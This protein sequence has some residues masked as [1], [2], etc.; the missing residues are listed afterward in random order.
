MCPRPDYWPKDAKTHIERAGLG[1]MGWNLNVPSIERHGA[2]SFPTFVDLAPKQA[3]GAPQNPVTDPDDFVM[4]GQPLVP[5]CI[6]NAQGK[7]GTGLGTDPATFP[8]ELSGWTYYHPETD[9]FVRAFRAPDYSSWVVQTKSGLWMTFGVPLDD[10]ADLSG[11]E[12]HY[13]TTFGTVVAAA[14]NT[15]VYRWDLV[16]QSDAINSSVRNE[17]VYKWASLWQGDGEQ[18][19]SQGYGLRYLTD[20]YDTRNI[21]LGAIDLS[22]FAHHTHLFWRG[23]D[24]TLEYSPGWKSTP[25]RVLG[26]V[27]VS[28]VPMTGGPG[29]TRTLVRLYHLTYSPEG[30]YEQRFL[31]GFEVHGCSASESGGNIADPT[32][33]AYGGVCPSLPATSLNYL[34]PVG[35]PEWPALTLTNTKTIASLGYSTGSVQAAMIDV[36][37]DGASDLLTSNLVPDKNDALADPTTAQVLLSS[38]GTTV[39]AAPDIVTNGPRY[40]TPYYLLPTS[41]SYWGD[42]TGTGQQS[43]MYYDDD[44]GGPKYTQAWDGTGETAVG[45]PSYEIYSFGGA[46]T[47]GTTGT[48]LP[49]WPGLGPYRIMP[50]W[51]TAS[52][53]D[54]TSAYDNERWWEQAKVFDIDGDGLTDVGLIQESRAYPV[55]GAWRSYFTMRPKNGDVNNGLFVRKVFHS[56]L[57]NYN[58]GS[59]HAVADMDADGLADIVEIEQSQ[60]SGSSTFGTTNDLR[61]WKNRGDGR[62]GDVGNANY[63]WDSGQ[64]ASADLNVATC[65]A[66][67]WPVDQHK[68]NIA[69]GDVNGDQLADFVVLYNKTLS[70]YTQRPRAVQSDGHGNFSPAITLANA[71]ADDDVAISIADM[72]GAGIASIVLADGN[73]VSMFQLTQSHYGLLTNIT[74]GAGRMTTIT[75]DSVTHLGKTA[76]PAWQTTLPVPTQVVVS[77][78]TSSPDKEPDGTSDT[79]QTT[80]AY[81]D[82]FFDGRDHA[83]L[84]FRVVTESTNG[85]AAA[86]GTTTTTTYVPPLCSTMPCYGV[87]YGWRFRRGLVSSVQVSDA[88]TGQMLSASI[89][90]WAYQVTHSGLDTRKVRMVYP[91]QVD[92]FVGGAAP[93][94]TSPLGTFGVTALGGVQPAAGTTDTTYAWPAPTVL[95]PGGR[96]GLW[97]VRR[98]QLLD[99]QGDMT[100]SVDF[101]LIFR[102][103]PI[104]TTNTWALPV[105]D[106]T[107][108]GFRVTQTKTGYADATGASFVGTPREVDSTYTTWGLPATVS[109]PLVGTLPLLRGNDSLPIAPAPPNASADSLAGAPL[110]LASYTYDDYSNLAKVQGPDLR[111]TGVTYDTSFNQLP[112]A[113]SAIRNSCKSAGDDL[114]TT[115]SYDRGLGQITLEVSPSLATTIRHYDAF[116]RLTEVDQPNAL[117]LGTTATTAAMSVDWSQYPRQLH[118]TT[119]A[120]ESFINYDSYGRARYRLDSAETKSSWIVSGAAQLYPNGRVQRAFVSFAWSGSTA[121]KAVTT[122]SSSSTSYTYDALGRV[123]TSTGLDG[124]VTGQYVYPPL[125]TDMRDGEQSL[126]GSLH[127]GSSSSAVRDGHGRTVSLVETTISPADVV[128]TGTAYLATGEVQSILKS[129]TGGIDTFSRTL[130]YDS[131]G[132]LVQ[133]IEPNTTASFKG[134][135]GDPAHMAAWR[136]AYDDAGDLVGTADARGCGKNLTYDTLGRLLGEDYSPC[137]SGQAPY[138]PV[139]SG[140]AGYEALYVYDVPETGSGATT[141]AVYQGKLTATYDRGEH[142]Q[143]LYDARGRAIGLRKQLAVPGTTSANAA[144][145]YA[146]HWFEQDVSAYDEANRVVTRTTGMDPAVFGLAASTYLTTHY[147]ARGTVTS[148]DGSYGALLASQTFNP[149][150]TLLQQVYGDAAKTTSDFLYNAAGRVQSVHVHRPTGPWASSASYSKP[151]TNIEDDLLDLGILYDH[152]GNPTVI[153]DSSQAA[154]PAGSRPQYSRV[155]VYDDNYRLNSVATQYGATSSTPDDVFVSPYAPEVAEGSRQFPTLLAPKNRVRAQSYSYDWMGD[156]TA[157]SDDANAFADRSLGTITNGGPPTSISARAPG[158]NQLISAVQGTSSLGVTY[159]E[160]GDVTGISL[161][162]GAPCASDCDTYYAYAWDEVGHLATADRSETLAPGL[163]EWVVKETFAYDSSGGRV[164]KEYQTN[165]SEVPATYTANVFDSLRLEGTTFPDANGDY[166][167]TT[168]TE[169]AMLV[170][171]GVTYGRALYSQSDPVVSA[172]GTEH[173]FLEIGDYLGS[174]AFVIDRATGEVVERSSYQAYGAPDS[175]YR[176][177]RWANFREEFRYTGQEDDAEVGLTYFGARYYAPML[178]RWLSADP[179]TVH[180]LGSDL[181]PYAFVR[182]SPFRFVDPN[183]LDGECLGSEQCGAGGDGGGY[184][185]SAGGDWT[186]GG[187]Y[188]AASTGGGGGR[189]Y[190]EATGTIQR[191]PTPP[192]PP[193]APT[194]G[195][196][197]GGGWFTPMTA[198]QSLAINIAVVKGAWNV[199][200]WFSPTIAPTVHLIENVVTALDS[201]N[202]E[203]ERLRGGLFAIAAIIPAEPALAEGVQVVDEAAVQ[204]SSAAEE[205]SAVLNGAGTPYP[206]VPNLATGQA[207]PEPPAG[208]TKVAFGDRVPWGAQE[209]GAFIKQWYDRGLP[210]PE[211]GWA[212]YDIHHIIPREY[213]GTN[214]FEN[215][216]PIVRS[217]HQNVFNAWWRG[218]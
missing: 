44:C 172:S 176:A 85:S 90:T 32:T 185:D 19:A 58:P 161:N 180:T 71:A 98:T 101:G 135:P 203:A 212:E 138:S 134:V 208:L 50:F 106:D 117:V 140:T 121:P 205:G 113:V 188:S 104:L 34:E 213:G 169:A 151:T 171:D 111:C 167:R 107:G 12:T 91:A 110:Q 193:P 173:V 23:H 196:R 79:Y 177:A 28:S 202:T 166:A 22:Q 5:I 194:T 200:R 122:F 155:M 108:W 118:V 102:D 49:S 48:T 72:D 217:V 190:N 103:T 195:A 70:V 10:S 182:G 148:V 116:G 35:N 119:P 15:Y 147:S 9:S 7:C 54:Y 215:L 191:K 187:S 2:S 92:T 17:V 43:V 192:P 204:V 39:S 27:A 199:G 154:W 55:A 144:N 88:T 129:H 181:N 78:T 156:T 97:D 14:P 186:G 157:S 56:G 150:G 20:I 163:T 179:L 40:G 51:Q 62:Y 99:V 11:L 214:V 6:V 210:T 87:D 126:A 38:T 8:T 82:P 206:T 184:D 125:E 159:D 128:T 59:Y 165:S 3:P 170:A 77:A 89:T 83:F 109:A 33:W 37:G 24:T 201:S 45:F 124:A 130:Q 65:P 18:P 46:G 216:V 189:A 137:T 53:L 142:A 86:P 4:G 93:G 114:T 100:Q 63:W 57:A 61:W 146:P 164:L 16:R 197:T 136:Y 198:S 26:D 66:C 96:A 218:Y 132:R 207:I 73:K 81:T 123:L 133:N 162:R 67:N 139:T 158:P 112:V 80:Y 95:V 168:S 145:A 36:D 74:D 52:D 149:D 183:G 143:F 64:P 178:G 127:A 30:F 21:T 68:S 131:L 115:F 41:Q 120:R 13:P 31:E 1:G 152:V 174:S 69:I 141:P 211:G 75:Y 94:T 160:A 209:R 105:G 29:S 25:A 60:A 76:S 47:P 84:G 175:D 42:W 153:T